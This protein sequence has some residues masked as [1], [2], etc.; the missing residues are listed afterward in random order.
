[1]SLGK[2]CPPWGGLSSYMQEEGLT[3]DWMRAGVVGSGTTKAK[4]TSIH[5]PSLN[6]IPTLHSAQALTQSLAWLHMLTELEIGTDI[7]RVCHAVA[8]NRPPDPPTMQNPRWNVLTELAVE[9]D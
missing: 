3:L 7:T 8:Y 4:K 5:S 6:A 2:C 9:I 1:M